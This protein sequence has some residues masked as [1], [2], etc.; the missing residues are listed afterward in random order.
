M[1]GNKLRC[2]VTAR[3]QDAVWTP[4]TLGLCSHIETCAEPSQSNRFFHC[5]IARGTGAT[6]LCRLGALWAAARRSAFVVLLLPNAMASNVIACLI[7]AD[8]AGE[9]SRSCA[10]WTFNWMGGRIIVTHLRAQAQGLIWR[11]A[12]SGDRRPNLIIVDDGLN[13]MT[14]GLWNALP[15]CSVGSLQRPAAVVIASNY[16]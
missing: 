13:Q 1:K 4:E 15:W 9:L 12:A 6:T 16:E 8:G 3:I 5:Q 7:K 2:Y 11:D 14:F 10:R